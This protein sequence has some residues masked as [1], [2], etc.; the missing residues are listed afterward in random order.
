VTDRGTS[1]QSRVPRHRPAHRQRHRAHHHPDRHRWSQAVGVAGPCWG[2]RGPGGLIVVQLLV[3]GFLAPASQ[4]GHLTLGLV[5]LSLGLW[6]FGPLSSGPAR[7][8]PCMPWPCAGLAPPHVT[9]CPTRFPQVDRSRVRGDLW[10][11]WRVEA[12]SLASRGGHGWGDSNSGPPPERFPGGG[13]IAPPDLWF[14]GTRG[15]RW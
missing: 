2:W 1:F 10:H 9:A 14:L 8:T 4:L 5:I 7:L 6:G 13:C 15:D 3:I 11:A 12:S